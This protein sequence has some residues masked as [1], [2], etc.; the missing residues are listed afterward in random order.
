NATNHHYDPVQALQ[1][2]PVE[3]IVAL[4][5]AGHQRLEEPHPAAGMLLDN[6]GAKVCSSVKELFEVTLKLTG[7][8]PVLLERDHNVPPLT[9]LLD[10]VRELRKIWRRLFPDQGECQ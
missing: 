4:H 5:I 3:K 8:L 7:P 1:Q 2:L 9:T 6:H 10:E